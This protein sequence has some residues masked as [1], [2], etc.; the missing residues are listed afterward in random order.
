[1][2]LSSSV[3]FVANQE[4]SDAASYPS[5]CDKLFQ[6]SRALAA[7]GLI[8]HPLPDPKAASRPKTSETESQEKRA[9]F[10]ED[11]LGQPLRPNAGAALLKCLRVFFRDCQEWEWIPIRFNPLR[12]LRSLRSL[13][14]LIGSDPMVMPQRRSQPMGIVLL[15]VQ[16]A[17]PWAMRSS[18][19]RMSP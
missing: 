1:M 17:R 13:R 15:H 18:I 4:L 9:R 5:V 7:L 6:V 11:R 19:G 8:R 10:P 16:Y 12:I 3:Q 2:S 14:N